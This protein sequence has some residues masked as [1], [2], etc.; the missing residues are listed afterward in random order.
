MI[1][2]IDIMENMATAVT[3][4]SK[5]V[6]SDFQMNFNNCATDHTNKT[7]TTALPDFVTATDRKSEIMIR[8]AMA[9]SNPGIAFVGEELGGDY[10]HDSFILVDGLDGT[11]NFVGLRD[12]FGICAAYIEGGE[13]R[14]AVIADPCRKML[15]KSAYGSGVFAQNSNGDKKIGVSSATPDELLHTMQLECEMPISGID[16]KISISTHGLRQSIRVCNAI[17]A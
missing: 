8:D 5:M 15:V 9:L 2:Y 4:A 6:A 17:I 13:V 11:S 16:K 1:H 14:A 12:Y 7:S 10:N 3:R